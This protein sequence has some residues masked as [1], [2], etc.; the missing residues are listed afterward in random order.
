MQLLLL[1]MLLLLLLCS[2]LLLLL[3]LLLPLLLLLLPLPFVLAVLASLF[4]CTSFCGVF[5]PSLF[6]NHMK[7][8]E[9]CDRGGCKNRYRRNYNLSCHG[10]TNRY[11]LREQDLK[12][13]KSENWARWIKHLD[14]VFK[15]EYHIVKHPHPPLPNENKIANT[16]KGSH[17][18]VIRRKFSSDI[19]QAKDHK[20]AFSIDS[21]NAINPKRKLQSESASP[22]VPPAPHERSQTKVPTSRWGYSE[23][24]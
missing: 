10:Y 12:Q 21:C 4:L 11:I 3:L 5:L 1:P 9:A 14:M 2:L 15:S 22:P 18:K 24:S 6:Q 20:R 13:Q 7:S 23:I 17:T 16:S 8:V 19:F